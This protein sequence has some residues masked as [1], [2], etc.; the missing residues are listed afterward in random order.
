MTILKPV[1]CA[2]LLRVSRK[3]ALIFIAFQEGLSSADI[4][5]IMGISRDKVRT[6]LAL[7]ISRM[8]DVKRCRRHGEGSGSG[9]EAA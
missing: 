5:R 1:Q 7:A 6:A 8:P 4:A 3:A 9:K 2:C